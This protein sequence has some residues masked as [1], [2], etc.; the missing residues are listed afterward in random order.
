MTGSCLEIESDGTR[1]LVDCGLFQGSRSLETLNHGAFAFA[2]EGIDAVVLTHAHIDHCGLLPKL[3]A[4]GF[5]GPIFCTDETS[6][7]LQ[8]MLADAGRIQEFEAQR[9]NQRRD[10]AGEGTFEPLYTEQDGL[11][12]W[13]QTRPVPLEEW[14]QPTPGFRARLWNAGHILGATSA[15]VD[16]GG[17]SL[18]CS[19]DLGPQYKA[20][21]ADPEGPS[22]L[23]YVICEATYGSRSRAKLTISERRDLLEGEINRA[24]SRGGNLVIPAFALERTQELLLDIAYL[25]DENRIPNV[26]VF[27]DSPL[28]NRATSVFARHAAELEDLKGK[29]IFHHPAIHYV[30]DAAVSMRINTMSGV[31]IIAASGMCEAGR[32]RHHLAHNLHR[33]DSTILFVGFQAQGSLGRIIL[34]GAKQV[35]ISGSDVNVRAHIRRIDSYSAH[36]D[37]AELLDWIKARNPISGSLFLTHGEP[38]AIAALTELVSDDDPSLSIVTPKIGECYQLQSGTPAKLAGTAR[39]DAAQLIG[40]DWQND[41]ADFAVSL[42]RQLARISETGNRQKAITEMRRVLERY[43][44]VHDSQTEP[45][46]D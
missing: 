29:D 44:D 46:R 6:E 17:V 7:L 28:A 34:E 31:I 22:G 1:I 43:S 42:K 40:R 36:A 5:E 39:T 20:F 8:Y 23:D 12:A 25:A 35:R 2:P 24:I 16:A 32:V 3:V 15:E 14:F 27:V 45:V 9:R 4:R 38:G 18:L 21:H 11:T 19:G 37:Q 33:R 26:P 30:D 10:R 41:Y 13:R